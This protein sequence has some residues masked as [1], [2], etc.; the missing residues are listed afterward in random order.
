M[1]RDAVNYSAI[2]EYYIK[3]SFAITHASLVN[4]RG[5]VAWLTGSWDT[6]DKKLRRLP[7]VILQALPTL[8]V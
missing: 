8:S 2:E 7:V 1:S 3:S 5:D 4:V 6:F